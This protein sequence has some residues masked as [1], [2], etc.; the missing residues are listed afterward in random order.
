MTPGKRHSGKKKKRQNDSKQVLAFI[1]ITRTNYLYFSLASVAI[2]KETDESKS[3]FEW[4]YKLVRAKVGTAIT[5]KWENLMKV[6]WQELR[7]F[8]ISK[9]SKRYSPFSLQK[10]L[11]C[12]DRVSR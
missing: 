8:G 11:V 2:S 5:F 7:S 6:N 1:Q 3:F 4:R 9:Y 12:R 10:W